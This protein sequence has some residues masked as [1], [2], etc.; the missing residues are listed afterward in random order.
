MNKK[1][2][3]EH[4]DKLTLDKMIS[5]LEKEDANLGELR[6]LATPMNYLR[7]NSVVSEKAKSSV[8]SETALRLKEARKRRRA[9]ESK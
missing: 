8:E 2:K 4:L 9:N 6:D 3:L 1:E 5:I 7:N